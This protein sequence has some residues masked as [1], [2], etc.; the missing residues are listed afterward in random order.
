VREHGVFS[1]GGFLSR[2]WRPAY[3]L[4][5]WAFTSAMLTVGA[6]W[7]RWSR[8]GSIDYTVLGLAAYELMLGLMET[9]PAETSRRASDRLISQ[10]PMTIPTVDICTKYRRASN[11]PGQAPK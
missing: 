5:P 9:A 8:G 2:F 3:P 11:V 4:L 7:D 6:M 1:L 10:R